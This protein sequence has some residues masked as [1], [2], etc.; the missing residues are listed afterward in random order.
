[1]NWHDY[2]E[3][4][5]PPLL[6]HLGDYLIITSIGQWCVCVC[7]CV[8]IVAL[9]RFG[10]AWGWS[11]FPPYLCCPLLRIWCIF[12][13]S[14]LLCQ[15]TLLLTHDVREDYLL[16][17]TIWSQI[18]I[19][20]GLSRTVHSYCWP[21]WEAPYNNNHRHVYNLNLNFT[22]LEHLHP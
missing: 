16:N 22:L 8:C 5:T 12:V 20:A 17:V 15:G 13:G 21:S 14:F 2:K 4:K 18:I 3:K 10:N 11:F 19:M 7:V 9:F 6:W 1:M